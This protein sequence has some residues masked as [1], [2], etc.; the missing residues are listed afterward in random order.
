MPLRLGKYLFKLK[1]NAK[2]YEN[3]NINGQELTSFKDKYLKII[4][5]L[6]C[7]ITLTYYLK[8]GFSDAFVSYVSSILSILVG[9]FITAIIFSFDKFYKKLDDKELETANSTQILLDKQAYNYSKQ[10]AYI[11]GY[12]IVLCIFTIILLSFSTL[13]GSTMS[14]NVF[15][16]EFVFQNIDIVSIKLFLSAVF[17]LSQRF[18][19]LYWISVVVYNTLFIV[20]SMVDYMIIK[21]DRK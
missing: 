2:K 11:T 21:I 10:F 19:V 17:I 1:R 18:F 7:A 6:S 5:C 13:F 15:E 3:I 20:S 12:N 16:Y 4:L 9:L 8:K 14:T